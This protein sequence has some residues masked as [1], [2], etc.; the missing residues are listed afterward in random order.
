MKR[1]TT[2][3]GPLQWMLVCCSTVFMLTSACSSGNSN[4][5]SSQS[6]E[7]EGT[8]L[9]EDFK[10]FYQQFHQDSAYQWEHID[11]PL[12]GLP[13]HADPEEKDF[14]DF[15]YTQDQWLMHRLFDQKHYRVNYII[16]SDI[17]IEERITDRKNQLTIVRR[18]AKGSGGWRLIYYAGLNKYSAVE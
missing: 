8:A 10:T 1:K 11:F 14:E 17:I 3:P 12:K 15:Y 18:F 13:D 6:A 5:S 4:N 9:P 16:L 7:N 2:L